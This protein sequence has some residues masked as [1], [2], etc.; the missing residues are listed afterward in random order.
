MDCTQE[1]P[2]YGYNTKYREAGIAVE[3]KKV[4]VAQ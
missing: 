3:C 2:E 4:I 1:M